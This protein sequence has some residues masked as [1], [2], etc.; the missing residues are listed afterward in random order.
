VGA[1]AVGQALAARIPGLGSVDGWILGGIAAALGVTGI[2]GCLIP[3]L[4]AA[5]MAPSEA[6]RYE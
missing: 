2:L 6:L 4:R 1:L 5:A 3:A